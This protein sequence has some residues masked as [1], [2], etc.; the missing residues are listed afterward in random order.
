MPS[1]IPI[2]TD[3]EWTVAEL[4]F[5][6][7]PDLERDTENPTL[8]RETGTAV[9]DALASGKIAMRGRKIDRPNGRGEPLTW[10]DSGYWQNVLFTYWFLDPTGSPA[11]VRHEKTAVEYADLRIDK[12]AALKVWPPPI[13]LREAAGKAYERTRGT[14]MSQAAETH[15]SEPDGILNHYISALF[16]YMRIVAQKPPSTIYEEIPGAEKASLR[17]W[18]EG[19]YNGGRIPCI[20]GDNLPRPPHSHV[21]FGRFCGGCKPD[22]GTETQVLK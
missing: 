5:H 20:K 10:I 16:A 22:A 4:F 7:C 18:P 8:R 1:P 6:I 19:G 13:P 17:L 12:T 11:D 3:R 9:L 14:E 15:S 2:D 21:G